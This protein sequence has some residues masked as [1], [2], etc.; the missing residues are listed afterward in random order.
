MQDEDGLGRCGTCIDFSQTKHGMKRET[1]NNKLQCKHY[2]NSSM[3]RKMML[4]KSG[5]PTEKL[6]EKGLQIEN[7][8]SCVT[9]RMHS[10]KDL[11]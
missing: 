9:R 2:I 4:A 7:C 11:V 3:Q 8:I 5:F 6:K 10:S 1:Q